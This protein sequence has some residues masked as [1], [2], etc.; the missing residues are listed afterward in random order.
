MKELITVKQ[1]MKMMNVSRGTLMKLAREN[2]CIVMIGSR[3][4]RIDYEKLL[5]CL[6][7]K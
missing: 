6:D 4:I 3:N 2:D 1:G 7:R 5:E